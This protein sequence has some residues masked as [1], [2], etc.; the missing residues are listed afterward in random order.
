MVNCCSG[1]GSQVF[2][3]Q[4]Q[5]TLIFEVIYV[6]IITTDILSQLWPANDFEKP[7]FFYGV[8]QNSKAQ[9]PALS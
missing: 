7:D 6:S 9:L 1:L 5:P 2:H 4:N 8:S 3:V